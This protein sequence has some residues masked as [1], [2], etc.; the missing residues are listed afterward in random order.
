MKKESRY[1]FYVSLIFLGV[2]IGVI[3]TSQLNFHQLSR[4]TISNKLTDEN[5][6]FP[7]NSG[8]MQQKTFNDNFSSRF[9]EINKSVTPSVV[10]IRA[11]RTVSSRAFREFHGGE[12]RGFFDRFREQPREYRQGASG[13]GIIVHPEGYILTNTHVVKG[14]TE[15]EVTLFDNRSYPGQIIGVDSLTEVAVI[16]I[17]TDDLTVAK[18]GNSDQLSVGEWVLAIGNPLELRNTITAGII[19]AIGRQMRIIGDDFGI[20]NFI[21]TDA[22]INP[23]NSGGALVDLHGN[24]IGVNTAI[25]TRSGYYEGYGFA[26]PINLAKTVMEDLITK[27]R[28]VRAY[29]GIEMLPMDYKKAKAYNME[30]PLGVFVN[31]LRDDGPAGRAGIR[32]EDIILAINETEVNRS[33]Q[34]QSFIAQQEPG[35]EVQV[36]VY[37]KGEKLVIP[38]VL[39]ERET[40]QARVQQITRNEEKEPEGLGLEVKNMTRRRAKEMRIEFTDG[41]VVTKVELYSNA[42]DAGLRLGVL[43]VKVNDEDVDNDS[44]FWQ[45]IDK[46]K[47]GDVVRLLV[48]IRDRQTRLFMEIP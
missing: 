14:A 44:D 31:N 38:V 9:I 34:I 28:V 29:L 32:P 47:S 26:I 8:S 41:L 7:D 6:S 4:A 36:T 13:S 30:K 12:D 23:G 42:F 19:S 18:M 24:V 48:K 21:Q 20:E 22:V 43:I 16:K 33:N 3:I 35:D 1:F 40:S 27:G 37:R 2:I 15:L 46:V 45:E 39:D 11:V 5:F 10:G 17:D 25:A